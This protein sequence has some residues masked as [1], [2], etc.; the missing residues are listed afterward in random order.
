[1]CLTK[2]QYC[3]IHEIKVN[4]VSIQHNSIHIGQGQTLLKVATY[5]NIHV[6]PRAVKYCFNTRFSCTINY[7]SVP[8]AKYIE[9]LMS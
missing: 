6:Y 1:M 5:F 8:K 9:L 3:L 7:I 2:F 4:K